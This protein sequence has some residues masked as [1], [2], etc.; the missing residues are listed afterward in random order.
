MVV[1][2]LHPGRP[3]VS[4]AAHFDD[5][6]DFLCTVER[7]PGS[8]EQKIKFLRAAWDAKMEAIPNSIQQSS[9]ALQLPMDRPHSSGNVCPMWTRQTSCA[10]KTCYPRA[11][12]L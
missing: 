7:H 1:D 4:K 3:N 5:L 12:C 8:F 9:D 11:V 6:E 10:V 2:V